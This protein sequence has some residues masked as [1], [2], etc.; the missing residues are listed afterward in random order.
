MKG[1]KGTTAHNAKMSKRKKEFDLVKDKI[2][3]HL[4]LTI[5]L[6]EASRTKPYK[7][8]EACRVA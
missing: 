5:P 6:T 7:N 1:E 3:A 2:S 8:L 4:D